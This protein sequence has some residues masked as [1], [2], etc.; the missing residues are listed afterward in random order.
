M[1]KLDGSEILKV[2]LDA[3]HGYNTAGKRTSDGSMREFE[4]NAEVA[5]IAKG[6]L[7]E[8][9]N[10][11]VH[12]THDPTGKTD[13][14]LDKRCEYAN[15]IMADVFVSIHA[16]AFGDGSWNNSDGIETYV[17]PTKPKEATALATKVQKNLIV[18]TGRDNRGV[19]T[20]NFQVLRETKMTAILVECGFMTN[21]EEAALLKTRAY[22]EKCARAIVDGLVAQY[23][24]KLKPKPKPAPKPAA[25]PAPAKGYFVQVGYFS[26][27]DNAENLVE[28]LDKKGFDAIIKP[29]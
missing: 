24:L 21:K 5:E 14:S 17:Y 12:F 2:I 6:M 18:Q 16:N 27:K 29:V 19:R 15:K 20:A 10:V 4:F 28:L 8:Y 11:Q 3:G 9:Q 1:V 13:V 22:R 25:K 26:N 23:G 7:N